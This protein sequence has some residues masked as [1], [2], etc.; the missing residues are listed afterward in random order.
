[1]FVSYVYGVKQKMLI[2][3]GFCFLLGFIIQGVFGVAATFLLYG[4]IGTVV[5]LWKKDRDVWMI[6][7]VVLVLDLLAILTFVLLLTNSNM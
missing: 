2:I 4:I 5:G 3:L 1:M 6:P 7:A